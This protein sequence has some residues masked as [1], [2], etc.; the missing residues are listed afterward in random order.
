MKSALFAAMLYACAFA[1][2]AQTPTAADRAVAQG[3][4]V[5]ADARR[6]AEQDAQAAATSRADQRYCLRQTGSRIQSR[7]KQDCAAYG[8]RYDRDDLQRTGEVDVASAL[9]K[10]DPSVR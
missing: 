9:R 8:R 1:A 7:A 5:G 6:A 4:R 10:L 3:A 2:G